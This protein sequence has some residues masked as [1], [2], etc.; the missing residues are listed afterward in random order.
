MRVSTTT[1][2]N[3]LVSSATRRTPLKACCH[4]TSPTFFYY[5]FGGLKRRLEMTQVT[6]KP[7]VIYG[8]DL[9]FYIT[10]V[11]ISKAFWIE[12]CALPQK[13]KMIAS[14][15]SFRL[16]IHR[17]VFFFSFLYRRNH[18]MI[19]WQ[20]LNLVGDRSSR[21]IFLTSRWQPA[22]ARVCVSSH[23]CKNPD[24]PPGV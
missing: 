8:D 3:W 11:M 10:S 5:Y 22:E 2:D 20:V 16:Y 17:R 24:T 23:T 1:L 21:I 6:T 14:R 7:C 19:T 12:R 13:T 15:L 18:L 4:P 9:V